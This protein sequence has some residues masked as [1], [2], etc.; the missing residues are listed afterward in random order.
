MLA[1]ATA[2]AISAWTAPVSSA[3]S[4]SSIPARAQ[5]QTPTPDTRATPSARVESLNAAL[6]EPKF[7]PGCSQVR[8][9]ARG[10]LAFGEQ[11]YVIDV[12]H[13]V[14]ELDFVVNCA[15]VRD[16]LTWRGK[17]LLLVEAPSGE[18]RFEEC[19]WP[20]HETWSLPKT[21]TDVRISRLYPD[22]GPFPMLAAS[23]DV[24]VLFTPGTIHRYENG[25]WSSVAIELGEHKLKGHPGHCVLDERRLWLGIDK[26][27]WG[28][29]LFSVSIDSGKWLGPANDLTDSGFDCVHD[30]ALA[31][32]GGVRVVCGLA[33]LGLRSGGLLT[34]DPTK[35]TYRVRSFGGAFT[36]LIDGPAGTLVEELAAD[37][38]ARL[39][40]EFVR[41]DGVWNAPPTSFEAVA[42]DARGRAV[43]LC[44]SL[45]LLRE[46]AP[47]AWEWLT[48]GWPDRG[49]GASD[50]I[51]VGDTAV[52]ASTRAGVLLVNL[53][54][55]GANRVA[56]R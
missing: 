20:A 7:L 1:F 2:L 13:G 21:I 19:L 5:E 27:E 22:R 40:S 26:G 53:E 46:S 45:G 43:L 31:P 48:P 47:D 50:L 17:T 4:T 16:A 29:Q 34:L 14:G 42:F 33:H 49:S 24:L 51:I 12:E 15:R 54:T 44:D 11:A 10:A 56:L 8:E 25:V 18:L 55:G 38:I 52:V 23:G 39:R 36:R 3:G 9:T 32:D 37:R 28:G 30:L 41:K 6:F 35:A